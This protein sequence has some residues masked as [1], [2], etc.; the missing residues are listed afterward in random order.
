M[1]A[2]N[3][4]YIY[5]GLRVVFVILI[6]SI[7]WFRTQGPT[8]PAVIVPHF[9]PP[10]QSALF[11]SPTDG[12]GLY[13]D[14]SPSKGEVCAQLAQMARSGF[15]LVM[16][17]SQLSGTIDEQLRYAYQAKLLGMKLSGTSRIH[18]L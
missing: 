6:T 11:P 1:Y 14:G 7:I 17:Y 9:V 10:T 18:D 12:F 13:E 5:S 16:N 2:K 3:E 8:P 15:K 4:I